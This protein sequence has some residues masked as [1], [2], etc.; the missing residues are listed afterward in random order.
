MINKLPKVSVVIPAYNKSNLTRKTILSILEQTYK[1]I[2]IILVDDGSTDD[3]K[4]NIM[5]L[6]KNIKYFYKENNGACSARN[7]GMSIATGEY[8]AH[9]DCDD[10]YY[11]SKIEKCINFLFYYS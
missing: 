3:T 6:N 2:E 1:N 9:I 8:I 11:R 7:F 5:S 4:E 10:I